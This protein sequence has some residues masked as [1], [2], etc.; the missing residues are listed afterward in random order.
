MKIMSFNN[1]VHKY[2]LKNEATSNIKF[3]N[4]LSSLFL[5]DFK[6]HLRDVP[7]SSDV[8]IVFLHPFKGTH[9]ILFIH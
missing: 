1:F 7:F 3:Q 6:I 8:G 2:G 9:W 5:S 4:I